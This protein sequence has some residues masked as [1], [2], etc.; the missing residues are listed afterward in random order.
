MYPLYLAGTLFLIYILLSFF[1]VNETVNTTR[2]IVYFERNFTFTFFVIISVILAPIVEE[3]A[4]RGHFLTKFK[5]QLVSIIFLLISICIKQN[6]L[7]ILL[8]C[9]HI[10]TYIISVVKKNET[11]NKI[12]MLTMVLLFGLFHVSE[13]ENITIYGILRLMYFATI[14][15]ILLFITINYSI[16]KAILIHSAYNLLIIS[17]IFYEIQFSNYN[18]LIENENISMSIKQKPYYSKSKNVLFNY[19]IKEG[20]TCNDCTLNAVLYGINSNE[21]ANVTAYKTFDVIIKKNKDISEKDFKTIIENTF[22][23][24]DKL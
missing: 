13:I 23:K 6:W 20:L 24:L 2:Q 12:A 14:G 9:I 8:S 18:V 17:I 19:D 11:L 1:T 5:I 4:F 10:F 22:K 15:S 3:I 21:I 16:K 7:L